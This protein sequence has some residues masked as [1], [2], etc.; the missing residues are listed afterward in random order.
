MMRQFFS[1]LLYLTMISAS[2]DPQQTVFY[3]IDAPRSKLGI[4]VYR[5]GLFKFLGH[6]HFIAAKNISGTI[7]LDE[8]AIERSSVSFKVESTSLTVVDPGVDEKELREVQEAME[9]ERVLDAQRHRE[10][11]FTSTTIAQAKSTTGRYELVLMGEL[12][13]HGVTRNIS[14]PVHVQ[15]AGNE[16]RAQGQTELL[17]TDYNMKPI[18]VGGGTIKVKDKVKITFDI[19]AL[20]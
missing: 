3:S 1:L 20:K 4:H 7:K 9:S 6:D 16:I 14:L 12:N 18:R 19:I 8:A 13:L 5:E 11:T 15:I 17:Q 10:I 2:A